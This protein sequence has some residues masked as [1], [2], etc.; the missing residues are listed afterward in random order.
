[1]KELITKAMEGLKEAGR[2]ES[3]NNSPEL[4]AE[5]ENKIDFDHISSS[6]TS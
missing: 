5:S 2:I 6:I 4:T 1:M 3:E